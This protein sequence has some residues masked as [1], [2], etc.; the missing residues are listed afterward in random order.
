MELQVHGRIVR[1]R[2]PNDLHA[3][4]RLS[5]VIPSRDLVV[6]EKQGPALGLER[7]ILIGNMKLTR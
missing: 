2:K 5:V 6:T 4:I 3:V 1:K 7:S